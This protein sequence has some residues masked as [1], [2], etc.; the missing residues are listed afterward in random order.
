MKVKQKA[1]QVDYDL[2]ADG[3]LFEVLRFRVQPEKEGL[4]ALRHGKH[5]LFPGS[6]PGRQHQDFFRSWTSSDAKC[7]R[8][9]RAA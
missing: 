2:P 7:P 8:L 9:S 1:E 5:L 4:V 3:D 6:D